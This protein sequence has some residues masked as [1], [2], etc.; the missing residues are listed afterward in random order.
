MSVLASGTTKALKIKGQK[1]K[2]KKLSYGEQKE[3]MAVSKDDEMSMMDN[4][5]VK[6]VIE[7]DIKDEKENKL[8]I[9][10]ESI[11]LLDAGFVND[12]AKEIME[13]NNL[14][15]EEAKNSEEPSKQT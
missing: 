10:I 5:V 1:I 6:S 3:S 7:W 15:Q 14:G 11:N 2:I 13:F 8:L 9:S 4:I 12:L